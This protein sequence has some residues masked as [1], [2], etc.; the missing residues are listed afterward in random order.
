MHASLWTKDV[1]HVHK[2]GTLKFVNNRA[3]NENLHPDVDTSFH[4]SHLS[5]GLQKKGLTMTLINVSSTS[6][7]MENMIVMSR[8]SSSL[9]GWRFDL[10]FIMW[11][12]CLV[13]MGP[14]LVQTWQTTNSIRTTN[15]F[16]GDFLPTFQFFDHTFHM[17]GLLFDVPHY[18]V[19]I[20]KAPLLDAYFQQVFKSSF[21]HCHF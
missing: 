18:I 11:M 19:K 16:D 17:V 10:I 7:V 6:R 2:E 15:D 20:W 5:R 3:F 9:Y 21:D 14:V 12:R 4:H 1:G 8:S 13:V